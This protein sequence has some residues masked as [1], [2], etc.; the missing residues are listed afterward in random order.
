MGMTKCK[1]CG[2]DVLTTAIKC[3]HCGVDNP[4]E[5]GKKYLIGIIVGL[6]IIWAAGSFMG[7]TPSNYPTRSA[8][9]EEVNSIVGCDSEYSDDKKKDIFNS[10]YKNHWMTW[11]GEVV[12]AEADGASLN[13]D[14]KGTQDLAVGFADKNA[15]YN[16]TKGSFITV[17]FLMKSAGGCFLPF[18]GEKATIVR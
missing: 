11:R 18:S 17:R 3:P 4:G 13:I 10:L 12:L 14:G 7:E 5:S 15:G 16:L 9:Y 1:T 8:S 6:V 2:I